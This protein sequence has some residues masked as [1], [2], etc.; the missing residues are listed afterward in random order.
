[1]DELAWKR[2]RGFKRLIHDGVEH[3]SAFVEKHHRHAADKPFRVL[4]SIKPIAAPT[5]V[6][7]SIH[8]GVLSLTYGSIRAIN[9][10]TEMADDWVVDRLAPGDVSA[11]GNR[12]CAAH[13]PPGTWSRQAEPVRRAG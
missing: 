2:L 9:R 7:R 3:G 5:R 13:R 1:M 6:V 12:P 4:A 11:S 8:D 10:A